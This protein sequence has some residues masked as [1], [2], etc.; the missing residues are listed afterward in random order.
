[1]DASMR[2]RVFERSMALISS[3]RCSRFGAELMKVFR[4]SIVKAYDRSPIAS[5]ADRKHM[6]RNV[7]TQ[8]RF[9]GVPARFAHT[10]FLLLT[11]IGMHGPPAL[12]SATRHPFARLGRVK[13]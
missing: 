7:R 3:I 1:M 5:Y 10:V 6:A 9:L 11:M 12:H 4:K 8:K 2:E 13:L